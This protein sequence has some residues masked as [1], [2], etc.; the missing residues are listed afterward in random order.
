[1][2]RVIPVFHDMADG[3]SMAIEAAWHQYAD[4]FAAG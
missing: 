3:V 1:M 2:P 4:D